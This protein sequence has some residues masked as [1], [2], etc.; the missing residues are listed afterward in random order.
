MANLRHL[1][2]EG[3]MAS[4]LNLLVPRFSFHLAKHFISHLTKKK[5]SSWGRHLLGIAVL[6]QVVSLLWKSWWKWPWRTPVWLPPWRRAMCMYPTLRKVF[7][8]GTVLLEMHHHWT[9][10]Q[11]H[12]AHLCLW[13]SHFKTALE[14]PPKRRWVTFFRRKGGQSIK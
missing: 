1:K 13:F 5:I 10:T 3:A 6:Y 11:P 12:S 14:S 9:S 8:C 4:A 2:G 7:H